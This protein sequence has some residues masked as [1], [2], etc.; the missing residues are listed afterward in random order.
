MI[1]YAFRFCSAP[2]FCRSDFLLN[3][4]IYKPARVVSLSLRAHC[5]CAVCF[6][7]T[8]RTNLAC[9]TR[10]PFYWTGPFP[11]ACCWPRVESAMKEVVHIL[12]SVTGRFPLFY[13]TMAQRK[14]HETS[15]T[16]SEDMIEA[17][18]TPGKVKS[19][20]QRQV[21]ERDRRTTKRAAN[22]TSVFHS[23]W[24]LWVNQQNPSAFYHLRVRFFF[25]FGFR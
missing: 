12:R 19:L 23:A 24:D 18:H 20:R 8:Q 11:R 4:A 25:H 2:H 6:S 7:S 13:R 1:S 17:A 22:E 9:G 15:D 3:R 21:I 10:L 5:V 16:D 14:L